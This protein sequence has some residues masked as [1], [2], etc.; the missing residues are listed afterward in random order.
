MRPVRN[1]QWPS[2]ERVHNDKLSYLFVYLNWDATVK[3]HLTNLQNIFFIFYKQVWESWSAG[4]F[5]EWTISGVYSI[6]HF[7][8][9]SGGIL[10][11]TLCR[12]FKILIQVW[13]YVPSAVNMNVTIYWVFWGISI[14]LSVALNFGGL[15]KLKLPTC[16]EG[17]FFHFIPLFSIMSK[18]E[19]NVFENRSSFFHKSH[20]KWFICINYN[21]FGFCLF[22]QRALHPPEVKHERLFIVSVLGF[23]VNLIGIF[24]FHHGS[25]AGIRCIP[26]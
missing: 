21:I 20:F 2:M 25:A 5:C 1:I 17:H 14:P 3:F 24:V 18:E 15:K 13:L 12:Y 22:W 7:I 26:I 6:L 23:F 10:L 8:W 11:F 19:A 4:R 16:C 9:S